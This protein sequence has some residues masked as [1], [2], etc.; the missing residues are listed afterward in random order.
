MNNKVY[1]PKLMQSF[2]ELVKF[3]ESQRNTK[4]MDEV[5]VRCVNIAFVRQR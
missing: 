1:S 4:Y 3:E 5:I 2:E